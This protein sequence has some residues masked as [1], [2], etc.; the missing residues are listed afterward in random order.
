MII[1]NRIKA[2]LIFIAFV[3]VPV[4]YSHGESQIHARKKQLRHEENLLNTQPDAGLEILSEST[5]E[6]YL[7]VGLKRNPKL[8]SAFY[9]WKAAFYKIAQAFSLPDPQLTYTD[10]LEPVETRVGPQNYAVSIT[11]KFPMLDKLWIRKSQTF[12]KAEMAYY[13]F[14]KQRL[15]VI[16]QITDAY[17]EYV[18]LNKAVLL[19]KENM[20]LLGNFESVA[21]SR[22]AG[23]L[24]KNQDLLKVQVELGKLENELYSLEDFRTTLVARLNALLNFSQTHLLPWPK[25][26]LEDVTLSSDYDDIQKLMEFLRNNNPQLRALTEN[27]KQ[28]R[29]ALKLSRKEYFPDVTVGF[30][31]IDTGRA[32]NPT[33]ADSGKDAQMVMVSVNVPIWFDRLG[34]A[35]Q[36]AKA[37]L[38]SSEVSR[39]DTENE[40]LSKLALVNYKLHD[41]F[42]QSGLYKDALIPKAVQTLNAMQSG[43]ESGDIDF[44]SLIDA[45][46]VLLNFQ[47][48]YYR[49]NANFNQRCVELKSLLGQVDDY[50][51]DQF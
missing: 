2:F 40:L 47:L 45:Q 21:Q 36:E 14:E 17:Y 28:L 10:Y 12:K 49:H 33:L 26:A 22:Y 13:D 27:V 5:L 3:F 16:Y 30:T 23:G 37:A 35:V 1:K 29:D 32:L 34:A 6:D 19:T 38:K 25:E 9:Q 24:Q 50:S 48:A 43:Y 11:Q 42:R 44:L 15:D 8:K 31:Q 51:S 46:R 41:S 20:K 18:Y 4:S 39:E 7:T